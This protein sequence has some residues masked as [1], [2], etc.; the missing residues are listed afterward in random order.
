M[1]LPAT[2][3]VL[4]SPT[5]S[6]WCTTDRLTDGWSSHW[7]GMGRGLGGLVRIDGVTKRF[8][9][10]T[11]HAPPIE[12][13]A[14]DVLP[15]RTVYRFLD[16]QIALEV[17]FLTP[18]LPD[19]LDLLAAPVTWLQVSVR[20][21]DGRG[22]RIQLE[23][24]MSVDWATNDPGDPVIW[25]RITHPQ[26]TVL[27]A[28]TAAQRMLERSG[29]NLRADWGWQLFG[30][31]HQ[32]AQVVACAG[33]ADVMRRRFIDTGT[34]DPQDDH[35][36][37]RPPSRGWPTL[38]VAF[39]L[40]S[41]SA[42]AVSRR[43]QLAYDEVLVVECLGQRMPPWW[44][45]DGI[46]L[47]QLLGQLD[48]RFAELDARCAAFDARLLDEARRAGGDDYAVLCAAAYRQCLAAH[49][50]VAD[51]DGRPRHFSKENFSNGCIATVDVTY[52]GAPFFLL[53]SDE[54]LKGQLLPIL[55]YS[56][57][58]RW[59]FPFAPHDLGTYPLA[60][61]QVYGGG[62][63]D[64]TDQ[65]PVEECGN[66]LLLVAALA[67]LHQDLELA[68]RFAP[69]L[70]QWCRYLEQHGFDPGHQ[71]CTDDFAGHLARNANLAV[72]AILAVASWGRV[73]ALLGDAAEAARLATTAR[74]AAGA[75]QRLAVE[76]DHTVL[77]FGSP[78]TW[79]LKYNLVWD[80]LLALGV[81]PAE[82]ARREIAWYRT[83]QQRY[84]VPLDSRRSWAKNDWT[85]WAACLTNDAAAF[86][87]LAAPLRRWLEESPDHAPLSDWYEAD[88]GRV[89]GFRARSVVGGFFLRLLQVR[90][91]KPW[92][93]GIAG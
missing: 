50:L 87:E 19:D 22:H 92:N 82:V 57:S 25:H 58:R 24:D 3:L 20:S 72:K 45:R 59:R 5:F 7:T 40:G 86:R 77:A 41:V 39:D 11:H 16:S 85:L 78:G 34:I 93:D 76:G 15:T 29:D 90:G 62:E 51:R 37:P 27:R 61:G 36:L 73:E 6:T 65:M 60:N 54:L 63:D 89:A 55:E 38:T 68:R 43:V 12:Q 56:A 8:L 46:E 53:F 9:G 2:P 33:V 67:I 31:P 13:T 70:R 84:G 69:Q 91:G 30:V 23:L 49:G 48:A 42:G 17:T 32:G 75:W 52:P 21:I 64:E 71:L 79:S 35:H 83:H 44:A 28:G 18:A 26:L 1:R 4:H 14:C 47:D 88:S 81:F 74:Q 66:L 80:E 10:A